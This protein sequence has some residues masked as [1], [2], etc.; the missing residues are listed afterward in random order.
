MLQLADRR[1]GTRSPDYS[2]TATWKRT[3]SISRRGDPLRGEVVTI[4][5]S[6][7]QLTLIRGTP[8]PVPLTAPR[9]V[10][11]AI[12]RFFDITISLLLL[13]LFLPALLVIA[14]AVQLSSSGAPIFSQMRE[15]LNGQPIKVYKFRT[16]Y[17]D[18]CDVDGVVQT[19]TDDPRV[20]HIGRF[21]RRTS[22][23]ELPQLINILKGEMSLI[24]PRPHA[25]GMLAG[26]SPY[27]RLVP[28]YAA[29]QSMKP[30]LSGW[31]Q[32]NGL[33]GPTDDPIK[34]R[35]RVE[36]DLAYIENFSILLDFRIIWKTLLQEFPN[37]TGL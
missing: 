9:Y 1:G 21:L 3:S 7:L 15:G 18:R 37:G 23:D 27:D 25:F 11:L 14:L 31:A 17:V 24:G 20:T 2:A 8:A 5:Q 10:Q 35:A 28:Y 30:G 22:L 33:R 19:V 29:R 34:A 16:M 26:G 13:V 32:A 12:K 36:H 6:G 4:P